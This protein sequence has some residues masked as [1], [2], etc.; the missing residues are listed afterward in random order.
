MGRSR[1]PSLQTGGLRDLFLRRVSL[2]AQEAQ[3]F[4]TPRDLRQSH[5]QSRPYPAFQM[6]DETER[7]QRKQDKFV[8]RVR[9]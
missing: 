5:L 9:N 6:T 7:S 2:L 1:V 8:R 3:Q 4:G